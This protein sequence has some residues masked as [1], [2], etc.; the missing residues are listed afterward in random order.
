MVG[1][2]AIMS[3]LFLGP[4]LAAWIVTLE[5]LNAMLWACAVGFAVSLI[6]VYAGLRQ[7]FSTQED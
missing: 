2:L 7:T 1:Q 6:L 3:G 4:N 5:N